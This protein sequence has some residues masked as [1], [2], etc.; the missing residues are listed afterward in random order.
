M[1]FKQGGW[2]EELYYRL[3]GYAHS[4]PDSSDGEMWESNGPIYVG[5]VFNDVFRLQASTYAACYL[6][7]KAGRPKLAVSKNSDFLFD[8]PKLLWSDEIVASYQAL[9]AA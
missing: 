2:M 5:K 3:C 1:L 7:A 6:L 8:T 4:R 9:C